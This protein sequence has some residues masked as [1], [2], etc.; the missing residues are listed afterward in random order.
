MAQQVVYTCDR[1]GQPG[2]VHLE[3]EVS[4]TP[5]KDAPNDEDV[6]IRL[7]DLCLADA[8]RGL[9]M[10]TEGMGYVAKRAWIAA[11][12]EKDKS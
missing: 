4:A 8:A 3:L 1:C 10:A 12:L 6:T 11:V 5:V 2:A 7:L 9:K